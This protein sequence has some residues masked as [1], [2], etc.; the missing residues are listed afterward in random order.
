MP[1][2]GLIRIEEP[3]N[4][5]VVVVIW[6]DVLT[7]I[8]FVPVDWVSQVKVMEKVPDVVVTVAMVRVFPKE[9]RSCPSSKPVPEIVIVVPTEPLSGVLRVRYAGVM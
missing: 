5:K 7:V 8:T 9:I 4:L 1:E 2:V 6:I 3:S